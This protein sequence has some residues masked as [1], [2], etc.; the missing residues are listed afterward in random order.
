MSALLGGKCYLHGAWAC[1]S[2]QCR[3]SMRLYVQAKIYL[4]KAK[5][6]LIPAGVVFYR[7]LPRDETGYVIESAVC[8][9][10][11]FC[12]MQTRSFAVPCPPTDSHP[13]QSLIRDSLLQ[14][15]GTYVCYELC[16][17]VLSAVRALCLRNA[18]IAPGLTGEGVPRVCSSI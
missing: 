9:T 12:R 1:K 6:G 17:C 4:P 11:P 13:T 14:M 5:N 10:C 7:Y 16:C 2:Q 8:N 3:L 18:I 15:Q